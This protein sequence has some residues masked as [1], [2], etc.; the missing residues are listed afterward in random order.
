M[1]IKIVYEKAP[2]VSDML[3]RR[4]GEGRRGATSEGR[5]REVCT[6]PVW[7]AAWRLWAAAPP[8]WALEAEIFPEACEASGAAL[9]DG[10][11]SLRRGT[12][13]VVA[14]AGLPV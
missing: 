8:W 3:H 14:G 11:F 5:E 2:G 9:A 13:R 12:G 1:A 6:G 10:V 4:G 7:Q